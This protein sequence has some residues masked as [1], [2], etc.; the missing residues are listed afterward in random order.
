MNGAPPVGFQSP[1]GMEWEEV[2]E[3]SWLRS[4]NS[5]G[6]GASPEVVG[7]SSNPVMTTSC[8]RHC[9]KGEGG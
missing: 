7:L 1:A 9:A 3:A 6:G 8:V 5:G 2:M 4:L